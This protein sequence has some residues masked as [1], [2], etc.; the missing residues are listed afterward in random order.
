MLYL[1]Q[2]VIVDSA[3]YIDALRAGEDI[4]QSL[5]PWL[6]NGLLFNCGVIRAEVLRG[7]KNRRLKDEMTAF[8]N[9]VPEVPTNARFWQEVAELAWVLDRTIGGA[10][11]LTDIAIAR[12]AMNVDAVLISPDQHFQ[13]IPGLRLKTELK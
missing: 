5:L 12:C 11:P 9:I 4:R 8:F 13:D 1:N 6:A 3:V 10:R 2:P 7:F